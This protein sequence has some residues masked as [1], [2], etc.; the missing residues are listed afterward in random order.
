MAIHSEHGDSMSDMIRQRL[1]FDKLFREKYSKEFI[2][3]EFKE[4]FP[5][6]MLYITK[7]ESKECP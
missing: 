3:A 7:Q 2:D 1:E 5:E 6:V 4:V